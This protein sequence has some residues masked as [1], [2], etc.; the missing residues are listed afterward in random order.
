MKVKR[1]SDWL[2]KVGVL[3]LRVMKCSVVGQYQTNGNQIILL[4]G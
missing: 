4:D 2:K 1:D 3:Y